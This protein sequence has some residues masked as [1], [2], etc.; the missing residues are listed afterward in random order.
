[1]K[2]AEISIQT[3]HEATEAVAEIFHELG[4]SGV[5]IE[6]PEL[7]NTY[8]HSELGIIQIYRLLKKQKLLQ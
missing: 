5:L 3:S 1:M 6:D 7:V 2:W 8:I 4:A